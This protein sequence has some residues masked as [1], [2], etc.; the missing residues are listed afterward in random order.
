MR[1]KGYF[2]RLFAVFSFFS[3]AMTSA[4]CQVEKE[5]ADTIRMEID[6]LHGGAGVI[7]F[8]AHHT[9]FEYCK[10]PASEAQE[11]AFTRD[12]VIHL[13][14]MSGQFAI[15][16]TLVLAQE[17]NVNLDT[18][19]SFYM[20]EFFNSGSREGYLHDIG[21]LSIRTIL[22]NTTGW[23]SRASIGISN[24]DIRKDLA[25]LLDRTSPRYVPGVCYSPSFDVLQL[26]GLLIEKVSGQSFD[27]FMKEHVFAPFAMRSSTFSVKE[28]IGSETSLYHSDGSPY[29]ESI[30][31]SAFSFS[32]A[33]SMRSTLS[34]LSAYGEALLMG[35]SDGIVGPIGNEI[36]K[37]LFS[38][39]IKRQLERDGIQTGAGWILSD[40]ELKYIGSVAWYSGVF[41]AQ[42]TFIF[43]LLDQ[44]LGLVITNNTY[45]KTGEV[46]IKRAAHNILKTYV[47]NSLH[48]NEP[49]F[50][51]PERSIP[52]ETKPPQGLYASPRGVLSLIVDDTMLALEMH[53][54]SAQFWHV[55]NNVYKPV[56]KN[57]YEELRFIPPE[58]VE[59]LWR[60][61]AKAVMTLVPPGRHYSYMKPGNY[62]ISDMYCAISLKGEQYTITD[63]SDREYLLLPLSEERFGILCDQTSV[64]WNVIIEIGKDGIIYIHKQ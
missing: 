17:Y 3:G 13:G 14:T 23:T 24:F 20:P 12:T 62:R 31:K 58:S 19:I 39:A 26:L 53:G 40:P 63:D 50:Q 6:N 27:V 35:L 49:F 16:A 22:T 5:T 64:F 11:Q 59:V 41:L 36:Q 29:E 8:D 18:P 46:D 2:L 60:S 57:E 42:Q 15:L 51:P 48:I 4:F 28:K 10:G 55:G 47:R 54:V 45:N 43:L 38:P 44:R 37:L 32:P 56:Q 30:V 34:D 52:I 1:R 21:A 7:I 61:G 9:L 25:T 33:F